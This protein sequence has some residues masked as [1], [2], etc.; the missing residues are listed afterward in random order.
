MESKPSTTVAKRKSPS[1]GA[2]MAPPPL[3][4][5]RIKRPPIVLDEDVYTEALSRIIARDFFPG[6]L[7]TRAQQEYLDAL[8]AQ[9]DEWIREAGHNLRV[10]MSPGRGRG[11]VSQTPASVATTVTPGATPTRQRGGETPAPTEFQ[12]NLSTTTNPPVDLSLSL[13][14]FQAKYT[15]E[16][17]ASFNGVLDAQNLARAKRYAHLRD[18][19]NI[20]PSKRRIAQQRVNEQRL[21]TSSSDADAPRPSQDLS[22][23]KASYASFPVRQGAK[24]SLMFSPDGIERDTIASAAESSSLAPPR[25]TNFAATRLPAEDSAPPPESPSLSAV[26]A[27]I[28]GHPRLAGS[29][30]GDA[31]S[32]I[33]GSAT[34]RVNGWAFVDEEP[35][36][37]ELAAQ[38]R[39][40]GAALTEEEVK[41]FLPKAETDGR[42]G[43][44]MTGPSSREDLHRR[45]VDKQGKRDR[46]AARLVRKEEGKGEGGMTPAARSLAGRIGTPA[47][48]GGVF[49]SPAGTKAKGKAWTPLR[50]PVRR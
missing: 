36:T 43:F 49:G 15:S 45:L 31:A 22:L 2:L 9:D 20:L 16:D 27:A 10:A 3:P 19:S 42:A 39:Q 14:A 34:P 37:N 13:Q 23:R 11:T 50:T 32:T 21:L 25:R 28:A 38:S 30:L 17:N 35:T 5:K 8:D 7:E 24:N 1:D 33:D 29:E 12:T 48:E 4:P 40:H 46:E 47:R 6:L 18:H 44:R 26:D 41:H